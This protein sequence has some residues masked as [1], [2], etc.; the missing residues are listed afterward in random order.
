MGDG[1]FQLRIDGKRETVLPLEKKEKRKHDFVH[2]SIFWQEI[3][4]SPSAFCFFSR[5]ETKSSG[6]ESKL[7][8]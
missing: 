5:V 4:E 7:E 6:K 1:A 2:L 3:Q 8:V